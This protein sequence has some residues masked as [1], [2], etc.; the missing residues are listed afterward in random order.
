MHLYSH[1]FLDFGFEYSLR[2]SISSL[3]RI[4]LGRA[5]SNGRSVAHPCLPLGANWETKLEEPFLGNIRHSLLPHSDNSSWEQALV[6]KGKVV[7][8][9][10]GD[11]E[12]CYEL[13]SS[14]IH[15]GP[16]YQPPCSMLGVYQPHVEHNDFVLLGETAELGNWMVNPLVKNEKV[17]LLETLRKQLEVI[18]SLPL[19]TQREMFGDVSLARE[20]PCWRGTWILA[21]LVD[22]LHFP[23]NSTRISVMPDCC[24]AS[25]GQAIYEVNFFPYRVDKGSWN[26]TVDLAMSALAGGS[27]G[28]NW[29]HAILILQGA[30]WGAGCAVALLWVFVRRQ[31]ATDAGNASGV[32]L[33]LP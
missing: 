7:L 22:G 6:R 5:D 21:V 2:R 9:G 31:R 11:F 10:S 20:P 25:S 15:Q 23:M 19:Q 27:E 4:A 32:P 24:D 26:N 18:C 30:I 13:A 29:R 12:H 28:E 14:L 17:P 16:C 1:S 3:V 33:L 8:R